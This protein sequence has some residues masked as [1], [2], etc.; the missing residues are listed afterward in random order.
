LPLRVA[1]EKAQMIGRCG[2]HQLGFALLRQRDPPSHEAVVKSIVPP[3][4]TVDRDV[5]VWSLL[6]LAVRA[7][8]DEEANASRVNRRLVD[9]AQ[10]M[11]FMPFPP[12]SYVHSW[13]SC[14]SCTTS[15]LFIVTGVYD[16]LRESLSVRVSLI[17]LWKFHPF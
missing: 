5:F 8:A 12:W 2:R 14:A 13:P 4:P 10:Y 16:G 7:G 17:S 3:L 11:N 6:R 9:W 15:D 1:V